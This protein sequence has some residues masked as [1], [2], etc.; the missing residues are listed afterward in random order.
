MSEDLDPITFELLRHRLVA[1]NDEA[2]FTIMQVSANQIA[3]DSNDLN[4]A[5]MTAGGEVVVFG[6]WILV[7]S[8]SLNTLV[9]RILKDYKENPGIE[10][11]D[12]FMCNDPYVTGRHQLDVVVVAPIIRDGELLAWSGTIVH[13]NDVGGPVAGGFA[14]G[15]RNIYAE[16]IPMAP[17]K[18][19]ERG[20]LRRD[21]ESEYLIRSRTP[22][23]NRLDLLAQ[24][25]ANRLHG[26]RVEEL[27]AHYGAKAFTATLDRLLDT[28]ESRLRRRLGA[29]ADGRWRHVGYMEHDGVEDNVYR[30]SL[31]ATKIGDHL[32]LDFTGSSD[33]AQGMVNAAHGTMRCFAVVA[34]LAMLGFDDLPWVPGAFERVVTFVTRPG[35][36]T[37]ATWPAGV[38]MS[39]TAA[40][41]E[42]RT[43]VQQCVAAM[44]DTSEEWSAKVMTSGMTSAPG[45]ALSGTNLRGE[46]FSS[47]LV[48]AQLGGGGARSF[49]D[50]EDTAGLLHSPGAT[51]SNIELN[52]RNFPIF[53]LHR[54]ERADSGGPGLT[55][56]GVGSEHAFVLRPGMDRMDLT[57]FGHGVQQPSSAGLS[58]GD[59]GRQNAFHFQRDGSPGL[60]ELVT[61]QPVPGAMHLGTSEAPPPKALT[62]IGASDIFT[63][64]CAGGGGI[65]DPIERD[66]EAV[67]YD[68]S[69]GLVTALGAAEDYK[70]ALVATGGDWVV[71]AEETARLR[72][73]ERRARLGGR[74]P[75]GPAGVP[76]GRRLST[77]LQLVD[78]DQGQVIACRRCG[79][80]LCPSDQNVKLALSMAE[81]PTWERWPLSQAYDGARR[82]VL[83]RFH[84][85]SCA[86]RLF[87]EVNLAGEPPVWT[88]EV[89]TT[90]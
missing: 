64:W 88:L 61:G 74:E 22:E 10:P 84:C 6:V 20:Q 48:D 83:R 13:Q 41:Q 54:Y 55:R 73:E 25:A 14:V 18:I 33:Q 81:T 38:S 87:V 12:M 29:L 63:T 76:A 66:P 86:T 67:R 23:L 85:P 57:I 52:E 46:S 47:I 59:P 89:L 78:T 35:T 50:G 82:F 5:L 79:V 65:G 51:T 49:A 3:T 36:V 39:G 72:S 24:I 90:P 37:H 4:S 43:A 60:A 1:I 62:S 31:V 45:V 32:E 56:G 15:A 2:T 70:V 16:A 11:G 42:I 27:C 58:G 19:V 26:E 40:G 30:I 75:A 7:H 8:C 69:E 34:L 80:E 21:V 17:M 9:Q 68:V 44:L 77:G 53:Y 71:D 28:T